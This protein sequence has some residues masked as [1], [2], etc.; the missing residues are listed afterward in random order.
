MHMRHFVAFLVTVFVIVATGSGADRD[1]LLAAEPLYLGTDAPSRVQPFMLTVENRGPETSGVITVQTNEFSMRY[2][3]DLPQG[4]RKRVIA[5]ITGSGYF[6]GKAT[7]DT[8]RGNAGFIIE[9]RAVGSSRCIA[10]I[11]DTP[12]DL[13]FIRGQRIK[14]PA[15]DV[16]LKPDMMPDRAA[17]YVG[18]IGVW[19]G[20][21][22]E[23]MNDDAAAALQRYVTTG[24][25]L[26]ISGGASMPI[27]GDPRWQSLLPVTNA[28]PRT[29]QLDTQL[30]GMTVSGNCTLGVGSL[31]SG[32]RTLLEVSGAP[33]VV[34]K[35]HGLGRV[36]YLAANMTEGPAKQW[37]GREAF[38]RKANAFTPMTPLT[39]LMESMN[40]DPRGYGA[41]GSAMYMPVSAPNNPFSARMPDTSTVVSILL[42]YFVIVVPINLIALRKLGKGELAWITAPIISLAFAAVFFKFSSGLYA[43]NL[44]VATSGV[45]VT[46]QGDPSG[47][48]LGHAQLFFPRGGRY[49]LG[50]EGVESVFTREQYTGN[51]NQIATMASLGMHDDGQIRASQASVTNL[52]F[53]EFSLMQKIQLGGDIKTRVVRKDGK[54][55]RVEVSNLTKYGLEQ[56]GVILSGASYHLGTLKPGETKSSKVVGYNPAEFA[57]GLAMTAVTQA[58]LKMTGTTVSVAKPNHGNGS[59]GAVTALMSG[60]R[61]GPQVGAVQDSIN[62]NWLIYTFNEGSE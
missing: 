57:P 43:A 56:V 30:W 54:I 39:Q 1:F 4:S 21:G 17:G 11:T 41:T 27:M 8:P 35:R 36:V 28:R 40:P 19:L 62:R 22:S 42:L 6:E 26:F 55:E 33:F 9:S 15:V 52:A 53:R 44:S 49:D 10:V 20:D 13:G 60:F 32:A 61:A 59:L 18:I 23:R 12:G 31:A 45:L 51:P 34:E 48:Y 47:T 25:T 37:L 16:Y 58:S 7:L 24:G 50:L 14:E 5:Y 38:L 3:I 2:P 29:V 46:H